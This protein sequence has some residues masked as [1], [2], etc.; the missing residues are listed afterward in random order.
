MVQNSITKGDH[1]EL[2]TDVPRLLPSSVRPQP[3]EMVMPIVGYQ[4]E[5]SRRSSKSVGTLDK[6][7]T[8]TRPSKEP[9]LTAKERKKMLALANA[10]ANAESDDSESVDLDLTTT[11][12]K[13]KK[14]TKDKPPS[15]PR[16]PKKPSEAA[17]L[18]SHEK[19]STDTRKKKRKK[20][21]S[22][23]SSDDEK[24][25]P[26]ASK[27]PAKGKEIEPGRGS[28]RRKGHAPSKTSGKRAR[29]DHSESLG[30]SPP[31]RKKKRGASVESPH[32]SSSDVPGPSRAMFPT[33]PTMGF[34]SGTG[35]KLVPNAVTFLTGP[36]E[37][38]S[39]DDNLASRNAHDEPLSPFD[40]EGELNMGEGNMTSY[41]RTKPTPPPPARVDST[42]IQVFTPSASLSPAPY[43]DA[44]RSSLHGSARSPGFPIN[45]SPDYNKPSTSNTAPRFA[46]VHDWLL[47]SDSDDAPVISRS[48]GTF[49][50]P[51]G[52]ALRGRHHAQ[53]SSHSSAP[54][55]KQF[56]SRGASGRES[57]TENS[58]ANV[59]APSLSTKPASDLSDTSIELLP[60][61]GQILGSNAGQ[62]HE[63][64]T[65]S[66]VMRTKAPS[67][68]RMQSSSP[69]QPPG[70]KKR[71]KRSTKT[72][73][74]LLSQAEDAEHHSG[75]DTSGVSN[76]KPIVEHKYT[77]KGRKPRRRPV[78]DR[79][80]EY[81]AM[82]A[83]LSGEDVV[84]GSTDTESEEDEYDRKFI[85]DGDVTQRS[86]Y[87]QS[88]IY[89]QGLQTQAPSGLNFANR[90]VRVGVFGQAFSRT[91]RRAAYLSSSPRRPDSE[92]AYEFG[93]FVVE[94][95]DVE[96]EG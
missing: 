34:I 27:K 92:D 54:A 75:S 10:L 28:S 8:K 91:S 52:Q 57:F 87:D 89:L 93:S 59:E 72:A 88:A 41:S 56:W 29:E 19:P 30:E 18:S 26:K 2:Y 78:Y 86:D 50:Q 23:S 64:E 74:T 42:R 68:P 85:A 15:K 7:V 20:M 96:G 32:S 81:V 77:T 14:T 79:N 11:K 95:E 40:D 61:S 76:D 4:R 71:R 62:F 47:D 39:D 37:I 66:F 12:G 65:G 55:A 84:G 67:E 1:I 46:G 21:E 6:Y 48:S 3:H 73:L 25:P 94:D 5:A 35:R 82:E 13:D 17:A 24:P 83:D 53:L 31:R 58:I 45:L 38:S 69:I 33:S 90:P 49:K 51:H 9:K 63:P 22:S 16:K 80:N 70:R 43:L 60:I 44:P 36:I